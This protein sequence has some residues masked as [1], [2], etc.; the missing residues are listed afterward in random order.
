MCVQSMPT[1]MAPCVQAKRIVTER[2]SI[3][4]PDTEVARL[5]DFWTN[6]MADS[7]REEDVRARSGVCGSQVFRAAFVLACLSAV[8]A[9]AP[10]AA[11]EA[12]HP[13]DLLVSFVPILLIGFLSVALP[14]WTG[15]AVGPRGSLEFLLA[16]HAT[17]LILGWMGLEPGLLLQVLATVAG[18]AILAR[19]A[20]VSRGNGTA[21]VVVLVGIHAVAG[22]AAAYMPHQNPELTRICL[23]AVVLLCLEIGGRIATALVTAAFQREALVPP[24]SAIPVLAISHRLFAIAAVTLWAFGMPCSIPAFFAGSAG[25]VRMLHLRP[26][27]VPRVAGIAAV[28]AGVA[29]VNLGFLG[30]AF[31]Q[32]AGYPASDV[33]VVHVWSV[34]GLGTTAIAVMTSVTRKRDRMSFRPSIIATSAYVLIA[35]T[36]LTRVSA[37][38]MTETGYG[39]LPVARLGWMAAFA[40]CLVFVVS[41]LCSG[42]RNK[43][44]MKPEGLVR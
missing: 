35:I 27:R 14:R 33:A 40:C 19:H 13:R 10:G 30:L 37:I 44:H 39:M 9:I 7:V 17:A 5:G 21:Y 43:W 3:P 26:W 8:T 12:S 16:C 38:A 41:G 28:L 4:T 22:S 11:Y 15:R 20:M 34:G 6:P 31:A 23:C 25:F 32:V 42:L 2:A 29:W 1:C 18:A 36:T 24:R